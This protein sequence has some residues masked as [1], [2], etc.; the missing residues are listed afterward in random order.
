[1]IPTSFE[2]KR[3]G[4]VSEALQMLKSHGD[5]A[6][7]LS[8]GHSLI[9]ALKLRLNN[10][11]VV[12]DISKIEALKS[13][14]LDGETLTI[15]ANCTHAQIASSDAVRAHMPMICETA[16]KIGDIQV[17]N[18]G[19]IGG[20]VAHADPA[21]DWPTVLIAAQANIQMEGPGGRRSVAA[22]EFFEGLYMTVLA[23]DEIITAIQIPS[24]P[25]CSSAYAK[26]VQPASRFALV[27]C[28]V[29][30]KVEGGTIS[31][32]TVALGGV[33]DHPV[34]DAAVEEALK[35]QPANEDTA[36]SAAE[37]AAES[38]DI[39]SDHFADE[40]YRKQMAKVFTRRALVAALS[41]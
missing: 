9:P 12:I 21:A 13:I 38:I 27:G 39:M 10:P 19:T 18:V 23:D 7:L 37:K 32:A 1:M 14:A 40:A 33:G 11:G 26:F 29:C 28:G 8:G 31:S 20:S 16:G 4:S 17:R 22:T 25:G 35:G 15:G 6:K 2:Y 34:R 41:S 24:A 30:L 36:A 5:D 3:A